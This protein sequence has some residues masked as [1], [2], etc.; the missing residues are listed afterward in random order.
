[1]K[2]S[3]NI[4]MRA[5]GDAH[6]LCARRGKALILTLIKFWQC[7]ILGVEMKLCVGDPGAFFLFASSIPDIG[8]SFG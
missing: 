3:G 8:R 1:M 7:S 6:Q 2:K 5:T 4:A